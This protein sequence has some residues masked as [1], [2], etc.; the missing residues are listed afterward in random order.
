MI[1]R[2]SLRSAID[3]GIVKN[4]DY[5]KEDDS[6][7]EFERFEKIYINHEGNKSIYSRIKPITILITKD[8]KTAEKLKSRFIDFLSNKEKITI[9]E[10]EDK[11][12]IVTSAAKHKRFLPLLYTIDNEDN[13]YEWI[14]SVSM[15]TEGWDV[16]NVF[17]I[18][19]MEEKAFSG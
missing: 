13:T 4:I 18:V 19:P 2:Y 12:L 14:V 3:D 5:V 8:I 17:Q 7:N 9:E 6:S 16:K 15:L 11:V 1:Y 10:A